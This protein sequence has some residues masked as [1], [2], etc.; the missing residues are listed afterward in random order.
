[1]LN[2]LKAFLDRA[3]TPPQKPAPRVLPPCKHQYCQRYTF[4]LK[5]RGEESIS[6]LG[7][8]DSL[9]SN[10][11]ETN[12]PTEDSDF[13]WDSDEGWGAFCQY[14]HYERCERCDPKSFN[15]ITSFKDYLT[16]ENREI[17]IC[18]PCIHGRCPGSRLK[19]L[20]LCSSCSHPACKQCMAKS[21][22]GIGMK[23]CQ[24]SNRCGN[25]VEKVARV[26]NA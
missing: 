4:C 21:N 23:C 13:A 19:I 3:R 20:I 18:T 25:S 11:F 6:F 22:Q 17:R 1:M 10:H 14:C 16:F 8:F 7:S 12:S 2:Q 5:E 9:L 15:K 26:A 24:C